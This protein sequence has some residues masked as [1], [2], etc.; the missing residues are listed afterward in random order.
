MALEKPLSDFLNN[1]QKD[2]KQLQKKIKQEGDHLV[3]KAKNAATKDNLNAK[4]KEVEHLVEQKLKKLEPTINRFV[5]E[6]NQTAK[7][8]GVDLTDLEKKVRTNLATA[9]GRLAKASGK[10]GSKKTTGKAKKAAPKK[11]AVKRAPAK[12]A[13]AAANSAASS[14]EAK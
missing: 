5:H 9:R 7:T 2:L 11:A 1:F 6:L 12:K 3:S 13:T 10:A 8:A 4:R 14:G